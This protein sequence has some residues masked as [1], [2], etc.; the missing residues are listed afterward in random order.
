MTT[1]AYCDGSA[2]LTLSDI[3]VLYKSGGFESA[4]GK[5]MIFKAKQTY[6]DSH[7]HLTIFQ[8]HSSNKYKNGNWKTYVY[9]DG[10][11]KEVI[12]KTK[13]DLYAYLYDFY[14]IQESAPTSFADAF[15][16][17]MEHKKTELGR[18][19]NTVNDDTRYFS[20]LSE[21]LKRKPLVD[22]QEDD[23]RRWLVSNY[24]PT[25]PKEAALRK[26]LQIINQTFKFGLVRKLCMSNAAEYIIADDYIK[27][28]DLSKKADEERA[29]SREELIAL[30]NSALKTPKNPRSLML[31][32]AKES[33]MRVGELAAFH[34]SDVKDGFL[35]VHRQQ[36]RIERN[37]HQEYCEVGYTKDER[38][39]PHGGRY[40]PITRECEMIIA[41]AEQLEGESVYLFHDKMGNAIVKDSYEHNLRRR[42]ERLGIETSN[43][44]AFRV[45]FNSRLIE[46]GLS[47]ADR[48]L[49]LGHAVQTN[50]HH[51]SVSD[52]RRLDEIR[53][54]LN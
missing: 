36:V 31:L 12:R 44:H 52:K 27:Y 38:K 33:G 46:L 49:I 50:E 45:A 51:Y 9:Q 35:H 42:C 40:I 32:M 26:M 17:L 54:K 14:K 43:N 29:F 3:M 7:H 4:E 21:S 8:M 1:T 28:C 23:L 2:T 30:A 20:Y 25:K 22:V 16:M 47:A 18:S 41:L 48:A 34:K 19:S 15:R 10:K 5:N 53:Q 39:H 24:L 37:G 6:V 13:E 11:R